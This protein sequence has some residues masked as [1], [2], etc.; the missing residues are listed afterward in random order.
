MFKKFVYPFEAAF[1]VVILLLGI[2]IFCLDIMIF[3]VVMAV[4]YT[5]KAHRAVLF[6]SNHILDSLECINDAVSNISEISED[7]LSK[8]E[9]NEN[10]D[11]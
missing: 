4:C 10:T 1:F 5:V 11:I 3:S 2:T 6:A 8:K 7:I 9:N